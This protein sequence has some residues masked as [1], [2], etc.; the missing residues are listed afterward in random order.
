MCEF[1]NDKYF[2][3]EA[4]K[5]SLE[6]HKRWKEEEIEKQK[7][8][9]TYKPPKS[10]EQLEQEHKEWLSKCDVP[11]AMDDGLALVLYIGTML[12]GVIFEDRWLIWIFATI[13]YLCHICRRQLH[14]AK[15]D[16]EHK[17]K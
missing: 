3:E 15:W 11:N 14:Q 8:H 5:R 7:K 16:R 4:M 12:G 2:G 6:L 9:G 10:P 17:N 13:I 1:D